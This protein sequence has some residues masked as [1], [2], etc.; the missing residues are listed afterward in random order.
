MEQKNLNEIEGQ[1]RPEV[2]A[3][4]SRDGRWL[5]FRVEGIEQPVILAANFVRAILETADKKRSQ[6][7]ANVEQIKG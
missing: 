1:K 2:K 4:T 6:A 5:I 3:R 7:P